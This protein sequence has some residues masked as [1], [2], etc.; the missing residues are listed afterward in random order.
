MIFIIIQDTLYVAPPRGTP[1]YK[2][3]FRSSVQKNGLPGEGRNEGLVPRNY[4][5]TNGFRGFSLARTLA[6]ILFVP[7]FRTPRNPEGVANLKKAICVARSDS[8]IGV[9]LY[10]FYCSSVSQLMMLALVNS[11]K[12]SRCIQT[13]TP[14]TVGSH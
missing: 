9:T 5:L 12:C 11:E 10:F 6:R 7:S 13:H 1:S 14:F 4:V 8:I 2:F 3:G